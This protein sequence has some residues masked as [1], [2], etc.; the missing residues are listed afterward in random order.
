MI[1]P[2][3]KRKLKELLIRD[4]VPLHDICEVA[5][6]NEE[7]TEALNRLKSSAS[8][9]DRPIRDMQHLLTLVGTNWVIN[10]LAQ[11]EAVQQKDGGIQ[12]A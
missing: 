9:G 11:Q 4:D 12:A 8:F 7:L 5:A 2:V 10:W 1:D 6:R 3:W